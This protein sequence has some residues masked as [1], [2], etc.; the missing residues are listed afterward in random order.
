MTDS[1]GWTDAQ[2]LATVGG[3]FGL[4]LLAIAVIVFVVWRQRSGRTAAL[5]TWATGR[6][7]EFHDGGAG[8]PDLTPAL[9][10]ASIAWQIRGSLNGASVIILDTSRWVGRNIGSASGRGQI[11]QTCETFLL[12]VMPG[13]LPTF[14]ARS[15]GGAGSSA[16]AALTIARQLGIESAVAEQSVV[17]FDEA[18]G[19]RVHAS[20]APRTHELLSGAPIEALAARP[21]WRLRGAGSI[22][23]VSW[24]D[25]AMPSE[26]ALEAQQMDEFVA[27]AAN[28]AATVRHAVTTR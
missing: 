22:L 1:A 27:G 3:I 4:V 13:Q 28:L 12:D 8:A 10:D 17:A 21:G 11:S 2:I 16:A 25:P 23:L 19:V 18:P 7:L 6:G 24:S 20:D 15:I 26:T 5:K 14:D 9:G